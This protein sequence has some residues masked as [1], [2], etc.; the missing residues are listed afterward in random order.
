MKNF[1]DKKCLKNF[2]KILTEDFDGDRIR[3]RKS[4]G[5]VI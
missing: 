5:A 4:K 2:E 1:T 3:F